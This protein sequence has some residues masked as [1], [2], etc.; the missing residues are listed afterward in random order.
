MSWSIIC[1]LNFFKFFFNKNLLCNR[2]V[3]PKETVAG[4]HSMVMGATHMFRGKYVTTVYYK[5][6]TDSVQQKL[7]M[8]Q[9]VD[10]DDV[11]ADLMM[12]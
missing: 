4:R 12:E 2:Y 10:N 7:D 11:A 9:M 3:L 6:D 5:R 1:N 8:D